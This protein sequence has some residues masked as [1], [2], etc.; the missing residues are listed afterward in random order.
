[1]PNMPPP[2]ITQASLSS[3]DEE[4]VEFCR[5][6]TTAMWTSRFE[7]REM[8]LKYGISLLNLKQQQRLLRDQ[9]E[10]NRKQLFWSRILAIATIG[11]ALATVLLI[12][13]G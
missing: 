1:M 11:I 10:Y 2:D 7:A 4:I 9:Q 12:K 6:A 8:Y 5:R 3:T 13:F